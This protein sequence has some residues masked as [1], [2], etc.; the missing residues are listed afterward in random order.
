MNPFVGFDDPA[1]GTRYAHGSGAHCIQLCDN[2]LV[3]PACIDHG[4]YL[5]RLRIGDPATIHQLLWNLQLLR[6][7]RGHLSATV[8]QQFISADRCK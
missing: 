1:V 6:Q 8:Y 3:D 7:A 4:H 2:R 5:E